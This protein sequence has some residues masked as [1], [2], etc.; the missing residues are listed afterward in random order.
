MTHPREAK[1]SFA[2]VRIADCL[3]EARWI[4][5][6]K[7]GDLCPRQLNRKIH[8]TLAAK[9]DEVDKFDS[10]EM[11]PPTVDVESPLSPTRLSEPISSTGCT[12]KVVGRVW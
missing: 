10:L 12:G 6:W 9:T 7:R 4:H 8:E 2:R 3:F 11:P 5:Y 1:E